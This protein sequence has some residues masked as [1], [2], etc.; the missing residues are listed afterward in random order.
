MDHI[1]AE[2][3]PPLFT[4]PAL[5]TPPDTALLDADFPINS[6][7]PSPMHPTI[8][9]AKTKMEYPWSRLARLEDQQSDR[10]IPLLFFVHL[11]NPLHHRLLG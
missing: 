8:M 3:I 4:L 6:T 1:P 10:R 5:F 9:V 11:L 7:Q 2:L